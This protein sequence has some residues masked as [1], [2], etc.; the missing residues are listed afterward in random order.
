MNDVF[1][2]AGF[3]RRLVEDGGRRASAL[4]RAGVRADDDGVAGLEGDQGL[5]HGRGGGIGGG[6]NGR[7]HAHRHAD[8]DNL[9]V[10]EFAQNAD[11]LDAAHSPRQP[12]AVQQILDVLVFGVAIAGLF[13]GQIGQAFGVSARRRGHALHNGVHLLLRIRAVFLPGGERL[14]DFGA[15]LL[16]GQE[17]FVF[18]HGP[19]L[20]AIA[21]R[22]DFLDLLMRAGNHV[23]AHQ[24]TDA[25]RRG[26]TRVRSG[27]DRADVAANLH[28]YQ[29]GADEFLADQD[30]VG[31]LDHGV[32]GFD[33]ADQTLCFNETQGLHHVA[34]GTGE[35]LTVAQFG[36]WGRGD[37]G[38][39]FGAVSYTHLRAHETR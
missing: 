37:T 13:D 19:L 39:R 2:R 20:L 10:G 16:Y 17:I 9:F 32:G 29:A 26:R 31:G 23:D 38:A 35:R 22:E 7:H 18:E 24:L 6:Q 11:R 4:E 15:D 27:L 1:R 25:A 28:Y 21:R 12:V 30:H 34:S 8:L 36:Q 14:F 3:E 5:R 33:S